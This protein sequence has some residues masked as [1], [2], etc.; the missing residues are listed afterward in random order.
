VPDAEVDED[1][2][3]D[4]GEHTP[5]TNPKKL[6]ETI[7][8]TSSMVKHIAAEMPELRKH[9]HNSV[10][11]AQSAQRE[12]FD[13][14]NEA[15]LAKQRIEDVR[16]RVEDLEPFKINAAAMQVQVASLG[17]KIGA[18]SGKR[19]WITGIIVTLVLALLASAG[20]AI[21]WASQVDAN[22]RHEQERRTAADE[23]ITTRI[24]TRPTRDEVLSRD[25]LKALRDELAR[26]REPSLQ[27]WLNSLP[28]AKRIAAE[29]LIDSEPAAVQ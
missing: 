16:K 20:G 7:G 17:E 8:K 14:K 5:I 1:D 26:Q 9:V 22:V 4:W 11:A 29:R 13:A 19:R 10:A 25:E 12:A 2:V 24:E 28:P 27:D 23:A 3:G 6:Y 21:W 15:T 18:G